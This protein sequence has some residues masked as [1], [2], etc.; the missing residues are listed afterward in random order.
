MLDDIRIVAYEDADDPLSAAMLFFW[1][2]SLPLQGQPDL[3]NALLRKAR[4]ASKGRPTTSLLLARYL[5][6]VDK[7]QNKAEIE[8]LVT[9]SIETLE[10]QGASWNP[11][12]YVYLEELFKNGYGLVLP[13]DSTRALK[14]FDLAKEAEDKSEHKE[15]K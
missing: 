2:D 3:V 11:Y 13:K 7:V 10:K 5:Y 8:L 4:I 1:G 15:S 9:K 12:A 6:D 14:Y